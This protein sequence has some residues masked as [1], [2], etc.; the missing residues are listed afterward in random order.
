MKLKALGI[1]AATG[2]AVLSLAACSTAPGGNSSAS[3]GTAIGDNFK[4]G[5]DLELSGAVA[6]YGNAGKKGA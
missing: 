6:A 2:L 3:K 5:Y 1:I 4:L